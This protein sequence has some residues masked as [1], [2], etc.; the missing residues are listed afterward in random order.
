MTNK[1]LAYTLLA[2]VLIAAAAIFGW[3]ATVNRQN[4]G[5]FVGDLNGQTTTSQTPQDNQAS[6]ATSNTPATTPAGTCQ[7]DF[8]PETLKNAKVDIKNR[9]VQL[10]VKDFGNITLELY[11][12]DA[13][14]TVENFLRLVNAGYYDCLTF[15]RVAKG[16]V[17]QGGDPTG[18][19]SGGDSAFGGQFADELNP[20]T[21]SYKAGYVKGVLAMANSGPNTN[22]SQFFIVLGD[23]S[24]PHNYTIFGKV[25]AGL[26]V[27]D[28]IGQV[29]ITPQLG[30]ADGAPITPVIIQKAVI[31]K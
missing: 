10:Q 30:P 14:K 5:V 24:L 6:A 17:V 11:D 8:N 29:E 19:G 25:T 16:F 7:R 1:A 20:N 23:V 13:P 27:V 21:A 22:T 26:D 12:Q 2:I 4:K 3:R 18:T 28:K 15:H 9:V 31:I